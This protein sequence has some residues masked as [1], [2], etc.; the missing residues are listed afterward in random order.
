MKNELSTSVA[1]IMRVMPDDLRR[2]FIVA[3]Y[4]ELVGYDPFE[5]DVCMTLEQGEKALC[6]VILEWEE[7]GIGPDAIRGLDR[8]I[9]L[10]SDLAAHDIAKFIAGEHKA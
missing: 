7:Q 2:K 5:D 1:G 6:D 9:N 8:A 4:T 10:F 3:A